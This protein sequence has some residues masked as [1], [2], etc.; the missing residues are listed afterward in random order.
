MRPVLGLGVDYQRNGA[1]NLRRL[2]ARLAGRLSHVSVVALLDGKEARSFQSIFPGLPVIH[3]LSGVAPCDSR[4]PHLDTLRAQD[5]ISC[6]IGAVWCGEDIGTWS[7]G[8]YDIPY[9]APPLFEESVADLIGERIGVVIDSASVAFLAE[10]P[11]CSFVA[12]RMSLGAFFHRIVERSGCGVVLD[13]SHVFSYAL[14]VGRDPLEVLDS[15]PLDAV[16]E[17]HVAGGKIS[18]RYDYLYIDSHDDPII[19]QVDAL[20]VA[21]LSRCSHLRAVTYE[22]GTKLSDDDIEG[23]I[24]RLERLLHAHDYVSDLHPVE[25][26]A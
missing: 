1:Q 18:P 23:E 7:I 17:I 10:V 5:Q 11:S 21:A 12:G 24:D 8:P 26:E 3:H 2:G 14:Y 25:A 6:Q 22:I 4:G 13:L 19:P 9:F 16:W 20:L 15:L